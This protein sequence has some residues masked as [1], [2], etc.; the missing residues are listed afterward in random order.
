MELNFILVDDYVVNGHSDVKS[1][2]WKRLLPLTYTRPVSYLRVGIDRVFEKWEAFL[3]TKVS[4]CTQN[5]LQQK[6]PLKLAKNNICILSNVIPHEKLV[7]VIKKLKTNEYLVDAD[8]KLIAYHIKGNDIDFD[9]TE[10]KVQ[11][12]YNEKTL[13]ITNVW[14]LFLLNEEIIEQDFERI[15]KGRTSAS[16]SETNTIIGPKENIFIEKG[17]YLEACIINTTNAKVY[18]GRKAKIHEGSILKDSIAVCD[19]AEVKMGARISGGTTLGTYSKAGGEVNNVIFQSYSNKGH[20][21][22]LGN[23]VI[24]EWCNLGADTNA[25]NL[26]NNYQQVKVWDYTAET[27]LD[28]NQLFCGLIMGDH[29]KCGINTMF[30]TGTVV[31][32][33]ANIYGAGFPKKFIPSFAWG[34]VEKIY[35]YKLSKALETARI[36]MKRRGIDLDETDIRILEEV[37]NISSKFRKNEK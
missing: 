10:G 32:V 17:A 3:E 16:I 18:I 25:S 26:K 20:D 33:S 13:R 24:G 12:N 11:K 22:Y 23:A 30:N 28:S 2:N 27:Y 6:F 35:E 14:D 5:Y 36:V 7:S 19:K 8:G 15:T 21:G 1:E 31:G 34:G 37:F 4:F 9:T 29:A